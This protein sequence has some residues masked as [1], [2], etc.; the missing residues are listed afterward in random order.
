M[1]R[2]SAIVVII[3]FV[4]SCQ[5]LTIDEKSQKSLAPIWGEYFQENFDGSKSLDVIVATNRKAKSTSFGCGGDQFGVAIDSTLKLGSCKV[6]VPKNH[7]VGDIVLTKDNRQSSQDFFKILESKSLE[8]SDFVKIL[9]DSKRTPLVFVHG[10]NVRYEEAILRAAQI[11]YDL[12]YQGPI[13]LFTWPAGA[14][15]GFIEQNLLNKTYDNNS[16]AA[17]ASI[18]TF[19]NFLIN[20]Q[21]S[22]IKINLMVHSMGHQVALP[23]LK[24]LAE[25]AS[26][27]TLINQLILNAPDFGVNDFRVIAKN[28]KKIS[29]QVTLYCSYNDKAML[30]SKAVNKN[31]RL[32]AC[33]L[34]DDVDVINVSAVDDPTLGLGHGYYSSRP[35]LSDVSQ[36]LIGIE[37]NRRLFVVK[38]EAN[39]A[40]KYFLRK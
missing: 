4:G 37:A 30:A 26:N 18:Q 6:N 28:I 15:D 31:D 9:K 27:K 8:Q 7:A 21:R 32:G 40:E 24:E 33:A 36:A 23:A 34:F 29:D 16:A 19:K 17:K 25:S 10:F 14:G 5:N 20:L 22:N 2:I 1:K 13:I 3:S 11:A 12:K 35:V 39:G 38:S